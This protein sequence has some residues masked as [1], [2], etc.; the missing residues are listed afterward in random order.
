[1]T[2]FEQFVQNLAASGFNFWFLI[3]ILFIIALALYLAF[4][5]I[6]VRQVK[7]MFETLKGMLDWPIKLIAWVHLAIAVFI[8]ILAFI[9]L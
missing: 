9:I 4:A 8:F 1:M 5:V 3:K 2:P 6:I 7:V